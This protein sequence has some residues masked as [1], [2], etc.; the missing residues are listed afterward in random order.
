MPEIMC[1]FHVP[2]NIYLFPSTQRQ[3]ARWV[4]CYDV[5]GPGP[6]DVRL[7]DTGTQKTTLKYM[8]IN[9]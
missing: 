8:R 9:I 1:R 6:F 3:I 2:N 7:P 4:K 5:T